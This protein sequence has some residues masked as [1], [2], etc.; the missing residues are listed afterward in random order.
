MESVDKA[1]I[2]AFL[3]RAIAASAMVQIL[4]TVSEWVIC[5][6]RPNYTQYLLDDTL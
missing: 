3:V 1:L 4:F 6:K 5:T 2:M